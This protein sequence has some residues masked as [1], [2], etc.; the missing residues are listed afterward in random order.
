MKEPFS[1]YKFKHP[2][3][4]EYNYA[5]STCSIS[6][7]RR[8]WNIWDHGGMEY[9]IFAEIWNKGA[10]ETILTKEQLTEE[11]LEISPYESD[12]IDDMLPVGYEICFGVSLRMYLSL[13]E[14][15]RINR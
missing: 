5:V 12:E 11:E 7:I 4:D 6:D 15:W 14:F 13:L 3:L 2:T 1:I 10:V 9:E 8:G